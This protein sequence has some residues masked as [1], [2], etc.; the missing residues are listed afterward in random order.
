THDYAL[1]LVT[2][3]IDSTGDPT[4]VY[5]PIFMND[6]TTG[7]IDAYD[8]IVSVNNY[9]NTTDPG[10]NTPSLD[11]AGA[12]EMAKY[13]R[14]QYLV[15]TEVPVFSWNFGDF[16]GA[17]VPGVELEV[18]TAENFGITKISDLIEDFSYS[19]GL[20]SSID[21]RPLGALHWW[22][23]EMDTWDSEAAL[24]E[25]KDA[26]SA[27]VSVEKLQG[28]APAKYELEQN[29]PNPFNPSTEIKFSI[30]NS[31]ATTLK[32]FNMLG[33][34]VATLLDAELSAGSYKYNFDASTLSSGIYF[35]TLEAGKYS[36]TKK[37][38]LLK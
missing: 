24:Q 36:E 6:V 12:D 28:M 8:N 10:L 21:G 35:Y 38:V 13:A 32:V 17:T 14:Q 7:L 16:N 34:E 30:P 4:Q 2:T 29:Y 1:S 23:G 19:S 37:M 22:D 27:L 11:Q 9:D 33:Q 3:D 20:T 26:Y 5:P 18:G 25:V 15:G 31:G